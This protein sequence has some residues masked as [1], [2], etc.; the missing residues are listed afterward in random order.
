MRLRGCATA[1]IAVGILGVVGLGSP[2]A[3]ATA[4]GA[5]GKIAFRRYLD[6]E[7]T[8]SALFTANSDGSAVRQITHPAKGVLDVEPDWSPNGK[9][10]VFQRGDANGCGAGCE[11]EEID[12]VSSDGSN[13]RRLAFDSAGKGC[14][15]ND[16][17]AGGICREVPAWSP[18][19][20]R[21]AFE[22]STLSGAARNPYLGRIC[23]MNADGSHVRR[24]PQAPAA[25]VEASA[26]SWS[27]D[28]RRIAFQEVVENAGGEPLRDAVFVM[29]A[30][31]GAVRQVTPWLLRAAQPDWS[32]DGK[33]ILFYSNWSGPSDVSANLYTI[34]A[35]GGGL[36]QL[37]HA[38]GGTVQH[39]S[40]T[41]SPDGKWIVFGKKPGTGKDGNAD[42]FVMRANGTHLRN[43]TR[44]AVWDS[45]ADWGPR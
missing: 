25:A 28:G 35:R 8:T 36:K 1:L 24:L 9:K 5:N 43:V 10:I 19:G 13:A 30:N 7:H 42:I 16:A 37:T 23:V 33:R 2:P 17:S 31:G 29:N 11:T 21:I 26:P 12:V 14:M 27:P 20:R 15:R 18:N 3:L 38:S 45:G 32:P 34:A 41:F 4:P 44:S 22:C 39:L 40:A 6:P